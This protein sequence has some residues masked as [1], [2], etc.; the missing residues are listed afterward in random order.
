MIIGT[1]FQFFFSL[2]NIIGHHSYVHTISLQPSCELLMGLFKLAFNS[3]L[4]IRGLGCL[5]KELLSFFGE[6]AEGVDGSR[7]I[8]LGHGLGSIFVK[9]LSG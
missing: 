6:D 5:Y 8:L 9:V 4:Q 3:T 7:G 1:T 2:L